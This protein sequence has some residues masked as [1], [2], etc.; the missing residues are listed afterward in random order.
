[1]KGNYLLA[2]LGLPVLALCRFGLAVIEIQSVH[3][4]GCHDLFEE[5]VQYIAVY[6]LLSIV[7]T[8]RE[9]VLIADG[10]DRENRLLVPV[11]IVVSGFYLAWSRT[12]R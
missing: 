7:E 10:M 11:G 3:A 12:Q 9:D 4:I 1:M 8:S 5:S 6:L 2:F